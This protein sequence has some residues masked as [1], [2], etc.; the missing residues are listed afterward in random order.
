MVFLRYVFTMAKYFKQPTGLLIPPEGY[1]KWHVSWTLDNV[2][3]GFK[4]FY[5]LH[6]R[7]PIGVDLRSCKFLPNPKTLE[8]NFGGIIVVRE[9]LGIREPHFNA[10]SRRSDRAT[11]LS[12]R[13]FV[14]EEE[15]Y[16]ILVK[17]F[18][19]PYVHN[20]GR[21]SLGEGKTGRA[22]FIVYHQRGKFFVDVFFP[23]KEHSRFVSNMIAKVRTYKHVDQKVFLVI[24]NPDIAQEAI[25]QYLVVAKSKLNPNLTFLTKHSFTRII[26]DYHPLPNPAIY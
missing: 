2:L 6:N 17:K 14:L 3:E 25:E 1:D 21:M 16:S 4:H 5:K 20:Q 24:G 7:W 13:A 22:D 18:H 23:D 10:G 19:E 9:H 12:S 11:N 26:G 15:I 8:R